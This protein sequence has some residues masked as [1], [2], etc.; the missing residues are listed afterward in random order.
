MNGKKARAL[1]EMA[2][3][4]TVGAKETAYCARKN[5]PKTFLLAPDCTRS[6]YQRMKKEYYRQ[7]KKA[8]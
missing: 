2:R 5:N 8:R 1:R 4:I 6:Y 7:H 3:R